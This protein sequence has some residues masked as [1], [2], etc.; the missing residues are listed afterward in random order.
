MLPKPNFMPSYLVRT[1]D[2]KVVK[3]SKV[4]EGYCTLTYS[5]NQSGEITKN[6]IT[7]N[8][9]RTD[10]GKH[11]IIY[12]GKTVRKKPRGRKRI[13]GK[14]KFVTFE[15]L[16]QEICKDFDIKY[17]W[18]DQ[19][20]LDDKDE[21]QRKREIH[22]M[23][24]IYKHGYCAIALVSELT[25]VAVPIAGGIAY[26]RI[27]YG[28]LAKKDIGILCFGPYRR[29]K[30]ICKASFS[31]STKSESTREAKYI[32]PI[33]KFDLPSWTG[34]YGEHYRGYKTFF[35]NYTVTGRALQ[36]T[37]RGMRNDQHH[38]EIPNLISIEDT[39]PPLP[40]QRPNGDCRWTLVI[41]IQ[42]SGS[43]KKKLVGIY[44]AGKR[45]TKLHIITREEI[46]Q[47]LQNLSHFLP[48]K[49]EN[50]Q[51]IPESSQLSVTW[52]Y[53]HQL[54]ETLQYSAQYVLLTG[55]C[56]TRSDSQLEARFPI[57]K[58]EGDYY[59]SI[60]MCRVDGGNHFFND[61]TL[62]EQIFE[63]Y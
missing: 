15:G 20:C 61:F 17:I 16:I 36:V 18:Y 14:V 39:R 49:K 23:Y 30:A 58:K 34:A 53:F 60:G 38:T 1:S 46:S 31:N 19:M 42:S 48:I 54:V 55:I 33:Q 51:W 29:Y 25:T 8:M 37:C 24:K 44:R 62:E 11:K 4:Q 21:E 63:I 7:G 43:T 41:S 59:K 56:F 5:W 10:Q 6:E 35:R 45:P 2:M 12:P 3:G 28:L 40:Q 57:I 32:I 47:I 26:Q 52:F 27:C 9:E 13:P 22:Q 50:L